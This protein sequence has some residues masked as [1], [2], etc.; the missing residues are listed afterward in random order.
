MEAERLDRIHIRDLLLRCVIGVREWERE[1]L[2]NV[3]LN[4]TLHADLRAACAGDALE[5]TVDYVAIKKRVIEL[6]EASAYGLL[7]TLAQAVADAC[8]EDPRVRRVDVTLEKPGA[9]RFARSVAVEI[10]RER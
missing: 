1:A 4:I 2:Q 10:S 7:E 9:L 8:L 5:D 3:L 6:V